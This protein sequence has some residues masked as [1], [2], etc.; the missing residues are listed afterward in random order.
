MINEHEGTPTQ[1]RTGR[2]GNT[3][4]K[5]HCHGR[6]DRIASPFEHLAADPTGV[7]V[8]RNHHGMC[9][10]LVQSRTGSRLLRRGRACRC[11]H[12][13]HDRQERHAVVHLHGSAQDV[14]TRLSGRA[15]PDGLVLTASVVK[16]SW[17]GWPHVF[18]VDLTEIRVPVLILHHEDDGCPSSPY[19]EAQALATAFLA[20][21]DAAYIT[22][23]VIYVDGGLTAA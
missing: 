13:H 17:T 23:Q 15:S 14:A 20:S 5:R 16:G 2:I 22:G 4:T 1:T 9:G 18:D 12:R 21:P 11:Q 8:G 6:I 10:T 19:A 7:P 3:K